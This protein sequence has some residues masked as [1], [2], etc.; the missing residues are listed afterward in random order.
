MGALERM[1]KSAIFGFL[2]V[3]LV[4]PF[5]VW[6]DSTSLGTVRGVRAARLSI[7]G[8]KTWLAVTGRALP[9]LD[10]AELRTTAG[11][12]VLD[13]SAALGLRTR[14]EDEQVDEATLELVRRRDEARRAGD[15]AAADAIRAQLIEQGWVVEDGPEGTRVHR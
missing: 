7:D 12:A 11:T 9:V 10:G 13:L 2:A 4:A 6:S 1:V 5:P 15:F 14:S 3:S 8:G